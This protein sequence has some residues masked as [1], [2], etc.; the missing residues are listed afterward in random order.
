MAARRS[1]TARAAPDGC[2]STGHRQ[3]PGRPVPKHGCLWQSP[4]RADIL[5]ERGVWSGLNLALASEA[6]G[7]QSQDQSQDWSEDWSGPV[8]SNQLH[9]T[10]RLGREAEG[11][12]SGFPLR[13]G[14]E[15]NM[16]Y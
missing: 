2:P 15:L 16:F 11:W 3:G 7:P 12:R 9:P 4:V 1:I 5:E 6:P 13:D 10:Q 14:K 8:D